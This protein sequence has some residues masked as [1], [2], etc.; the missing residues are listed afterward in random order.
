MAAKGH[1]LP[2]RVRLLKI[3]QVAG[4]NLMEAA[5]APNL[6]QPAH[7]HEAACFSLVLQGSYTEK[8]GTR[9]RICESSTVVFHPPSETHLVA[10]H[11][12]QVRI[13]R[14]ELNQSWLDQVRESSTIFDNPAHFCS[15]G[16]SWLALRLYKEFRQADN[17]AALAV[18]GLM[19]EIIA[20]ASRDR[21]QRTARRPPRSVE[22]AREILHEQFS[23]NLPLTRIA[24]MTGVHPVYLARAF[25]NYFGCSMGEYVRRLRIEAACHQLS[26]SELSL[27]EIASAV[28]FYDQSHFSNTFKRYTGVTPTEYRAAYR[29]G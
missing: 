4:L 17:F 21:E 28:G 15:S 16:I 6:R 25:R 20:E 27:S 10:L 7:T 29:A 11:N 13:L 26:G 9:T 2:A 18:Q 24:S 23:E 14:V 22:Q 3:R 5:Y 19:L 8:Y 12:T 1:A